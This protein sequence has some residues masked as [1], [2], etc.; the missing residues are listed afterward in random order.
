MKEHYI[1]VWYCSDSYAGTRAI[2]FDNELLC[3]GQKSGRK[4]SENFSYVSEEKFLEFYKYLK[5]FEASRVPKGSEIDM[6]GDLGDGYK[7]YFS[8]QIMNHKDAIYKGQLCEI[9]NKK[10]NDGY[11]CQVIEITYN[12]KNIIVEL[13]DVLFPYDTGE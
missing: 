13:R 5:S 7:I 10:P 9:I 4:S 1:E 8:S 12:N 2:F 6:N 3:I 11:T